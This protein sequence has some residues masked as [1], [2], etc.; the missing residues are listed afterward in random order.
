MGPAS[1][2]DAAPARREWLRQT[3]VLGGAGCAASLLGCASRPPAA[4]PT[5]TVPPPPQV[6]PFSSARPGDLPPAGWQPYVMRRDRPETRYRVVHDNDRRVLHARSRSA[7]S[8]LRCAVDIDPLQRPRLHFSWRVEH[9]PSRASVEEPESDDCPAR[10]ILAFDGDE[11]RLSLRDRLF[12]EQVEL[13]TGHRLPY[14]TLMYVW[15]GALPPDS[16][17]PNHRTARIRYVAVESGNGRAG[18]WLH[19]ERNVVADYQRIFGEA[20]GRISSVGVLTDSDALKFDVDAWYGD[21]SF[22]RG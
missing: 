10:I 20:P 15:D 13:F 8:G 4:A 6:T 14:A 5:D 9:V 16:V 22:A 12:Y 3:L 7:A 2:A 11:R 18:Q 21:I 19:Y 1:T 17:T